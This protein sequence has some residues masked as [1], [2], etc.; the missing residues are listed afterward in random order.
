MD[1]ERKFASPY[2]GMGNNPISSFDESGGFS[3]DPGPGILLL[4][5]EVQLGGGVHIG[6][7]LAGQSGW[8]YD[9]AGIVA[10]HTSANVLITD[11]NREVIFG[12]FA[13]QSWNI[14]YDSKNYLFEQ[15]ASRTITS[16]D[17]SLLT[18]QKDD[19][20]IGAGIGLAI[21]WQG[22]IVIIDARD[23]VTT[24]LGYT[25]A[26]A[27]FYNNGGSF[28]EIYIFEKEGRYYYGWDQRF[29]VYKIDVPGIDEAYGT[30]SYKN[31]REEIIRNN[32]V[33]D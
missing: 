24:F 25:Q 20:Y 26:D 32:N 6:A 30:A 19:G 17:L 18:I 4:F 10:F 8:A 7:I 15:W 12:D 11:L 9:Q 2:L 14:G 27:D 28:N 13:G 16:V 21:P 33:K 29:E 22:G 3:S 1:L 31:N 5:N 23:V